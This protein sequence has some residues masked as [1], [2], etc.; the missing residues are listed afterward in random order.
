MV[1]VSRPLCELNPIQITEVHH[2]IGKHVAGLIEDGAT[3]QLG[4][5]GIPDAVLLE[6]TRHQDLGVQTEMLSDSVIPL[7]ESGVLNGNRKSIHRGKIILSF[8]LGTKKLFD[9]VNNN[10]MFEFHP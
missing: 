5:G 1:E 9:Y 2:A 4:I 6:L 8:V 3:L 10:P 7:I